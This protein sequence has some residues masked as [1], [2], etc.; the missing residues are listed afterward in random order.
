LRCVCANAYIRRL[1]ILSDVRWRWIPGTLLA[2]GLAVAGAWFWRTHRP[3]S[4][5]PN[6]PTN[7]ARDP[8][9][10]VSEWQEDIA[11]LARELPRRHCKAF[12]KC[13]RQDFE[14]AASTLGDAVPRLSDEEAVVGLM[15]LVAMIGDAHT[16][17]DVGNL[18]PRFHQFPFTAYN[19]SDGP[20]IIAAREEQRDL[21]G[22]KLMTFGGVNADEAMRRVMTAS[23]FENEATFIANAPRLLSV[24]EIAQATGLIPTA[25]R[26]TIQVRDSQGEQRDVELTPLVPGEKLATAAMDEMRLPLSRRKGPHSNWFQLIPE[27]KALYLRY[28]TCADEPDQSVKSLTGQMLQAIDANSVERVIVDVRGNGGGNSGLLEPFMAGLKHRAAV[29]HPG[30][31][32]VLIGRHTFSSAHMNAAYLKEKLGAT[33][34]GEPT[35]QK[36]NSYGELQWLVLPHSQ[37][38][39]RYSTKYWHT[40]RGDPPSLDPDILVRS[41]SA[42]YFGLRDPELEAAMELPSR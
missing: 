6:P 42:D 7:W 31:I 14:A 23:A 35:G 36:P 30:G 11:F 25:A 26:V 32:L 38:I 33:L 29:N 8:A 13:R 17:I 24:P 39:V 40:A 16:A 10:R 18:K 9:A 4:A 34:I 1:K 22:C 37:I 15:K 21:I 19:F 2:L 28:N 3:L 41:S 12:F 27:R 5:A 20:V